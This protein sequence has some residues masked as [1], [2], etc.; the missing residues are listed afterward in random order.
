MTLRAVPAPADLAGSARRRRA[1]WLALAPLLPGLAF[2][3][4][5]FCYPVGQPL[6][7]SFT[8]RSG[9]FATDQYVQLI[10]RVPVPFRTSFLV[11]AFAWM[12]LLAHNAR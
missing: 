12:V 1:R 4:Y 8:S 7:L 10:I 3:L 6:W 9:A 5:F 11:R 2:L